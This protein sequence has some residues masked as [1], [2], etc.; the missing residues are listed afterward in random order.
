VGR[1]NRDALLSDGR[2]LPHH[3]FPKSGWI[4]FWIRGEKEVRPAL[5]LIQMAIMKN[6]RTASPLA[7]QTARLCSETRPAEAE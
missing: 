5:E 4:S 2:A 7:A 1:T 6:Q 3:I